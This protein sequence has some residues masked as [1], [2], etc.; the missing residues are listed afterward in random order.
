MMRRLEKLANRGIEIPEKTIFIA[1][2]HH[3]TSD[4]VE[5]LNK[6]L[7]SAE[8]LQKLKAD[9]K[10]ACNDLRQERIK[11]LPEDYDVYSRQT[12]W[13]ETI[14]ELGLINNA[15][16]IVGPRRITQGIN[17]KRRTFLHS[18]EPALDQD[19]SI[20]ESIFTAPVIV[21]HWINAQYYFS[22]VEPSVYGSGNKLIHNPVAQI[23]VM[24]GNLSDLKF[25]LPLQSISFKNQLQH[26]PIRLL[27]VVYAKQ[28]L[29]NQILDKHP[30]V[31][32]LFDGGWLKLN[33][34]EPVMEPI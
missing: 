21:A 34:I 3:T 28:Q 11:D 26:Q 2:C 9:L 22:T 5:L 17:L 31:K 8:Q 29:V 10:Q 12:N 18:Y 20:L 24:E 33:V 6:N 19:G 25:G 4:H 1:G 27:V 30:Q 16:I 23:G 7:L 15:A 13:A 14:P 32:S